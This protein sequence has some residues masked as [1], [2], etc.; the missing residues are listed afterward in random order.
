MITIKINK[1]LKIEKK[2]TF[3]KIIQY[4]KKKVST[5]FN[6]L[7]SLLRR[8][9]SVACEVFSDSIC[10][11]ISF[12]SFLKSIS[13]AYTVQK[14]SIAHNTIVPHFMIAYKRELLAGCRGA[15]TAL[16]DSDRNGQRTAHTL[17]IQNAGCVRRRCAQQ[18][19]RSPKPTMILF[20]AAQAFGQL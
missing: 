2:I 4:S 9:I 3:N 11:A 12:K 10:S 18:L 6:S 8:E 15:S 13:R 5:Y 7:I 17:I 16:G 1:L 14:D 20:H 19:F